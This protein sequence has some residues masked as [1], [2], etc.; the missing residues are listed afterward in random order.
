MNAYFYDP[1]DND[2][3]RLIPFY[4]KWGEFDLIMIEMYY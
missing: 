4:I 2:D 3:V 1:F